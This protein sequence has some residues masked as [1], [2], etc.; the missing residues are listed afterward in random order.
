MAREN[1]SVGLF[2]S[3]PLSTIDVNSLFS[4]Q[5]SR[6]L[7]NTLFPPI[8]PYRCSGE[9]GKE[10]DEAKTVQDSKKKVTEETVETRV[11]MVCLV[12]NL[13]DAPLSNLLDNH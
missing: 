2:S 1:G 3:S 12:A 9:Q 10:V 6:I 5:S 4:L 7:I 11:A 13:T 8:S